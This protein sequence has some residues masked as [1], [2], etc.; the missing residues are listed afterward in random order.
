MNILQMIKEVDYWMYKIGLVGLETSIEQI[1]VLAEEYK[2]ELEFISL[3]YVK[4]EEVDNIVKEYDSHVHAWLFSG[5]LPYEI[6]E[7][8]TR[9]R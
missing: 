5:P 7:K 4:T 8:N 1:L 9:Y 3:P 2:H 6:A